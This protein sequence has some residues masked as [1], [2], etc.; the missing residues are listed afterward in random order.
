MRVLQKDNSL[1]SRFRGNDKRRWRD[2][3]VPP[4]QWKRV[5]LDSCFRRN[6]KYQKFGLLRPP[7][8]SLCEAKRR[9]SSIRP[10]MIG[11][12]FGFYVLLFGFV[13]NAYALD[14]DKVKSSFIGGDYKA[15]IAQ[16]ESLLA[17]TDNNTLGLDE[18]YY[19]LGLS[20]MKA[21]NYLRASDIF[22]IIGSEFKK[23]PLRV[24]A[25]LALGDTF[26]LRGDYDKAEKRYQDL[27]NNKQAARLK[28]EVYYRLSRCA[29]KAGN[30]E[31]EKDYLAKLGK[32]FPLN[33]EAEVESEKRAVSAPAIDLKGGYTVQVGYFSNDTN[34]GKLL[35]ELTKK[36]YPAY[37]EKDDASGKRV[38]RVKVGKSAARGDVE[39]IEV[40]LSKE[41]YPTKICP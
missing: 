12:Y 28:Q 31:K 38:Y 4:I 33:S 36:G 41:G 29:A 24:D 11:I 14:L 34:A 35:H 23:S 22:E 3:N 8:A 1:D 2:R 7:A 9:G 25:A 20:Y 40:K 32:E 16:G 39:A 37:T 15:A 6:D 18:L 5:L 21:G 17:K 13:N 19:F 26:F 27:L 30:A 10:Q